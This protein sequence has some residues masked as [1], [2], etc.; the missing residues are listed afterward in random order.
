[1]AIAK[2][3]KIEIIALEKGQLE[4][5]A[6][7]QKLGIVQLIS[8]QSQDD[9]LASIG[10]YSDA[11]LLAIEEAITYLASFKERSFALGSIVQFK[12]L[13]YQQQLQ[14]VITKF[15]YQNLLRELLHLRNH[16]KITVQHKDRLLQERQL[17]APWEKLNLSLEDIHYQKHCAILLGIL[18]R[19]DYQNLSLDLDTQQINCYS[20]IINQDRDNL[21]LTIFYIKEDFERLEDFLKNHRFNFVTLSRHKCLVKERI[22][23]I[24]REMMVLDDQIAE[25]KLKISAL[26][27][28]QLQLMVV[29]DYLNNIRKTKE[30]EKNLA[31]QQFTFTLSGWVREKDIGKLTQIIE[32]KFKDVALFISEPQ[33]DD[34]IPVALENKRL[35][36]PFEF[37]TQIYGMPQYRELDPTP[38]L[39]PFF[40]LYFGFCV[41]DV[42]YGLILC[43]LCLFI[44]K[45]IKMGTQGKKFF[46]LFFYCGISTIIVGA[47]TGSWFGN[48]IDL[49]ADSNQIFLPLQKFKNALIV[50]DPLKEPTKLLGVALVLGI[51]QVWFGNFVAGIGNFKNKRYIEIL[52][53]QVPMFA[54]LFG[55]TGLGLVFLKLRGRENLNLFKFAALCGGIGLVLTQGRS[56]KGIAGK[57]FYGVYNLYNALSGYLSDILSYSR[58]WA[59]GLVT[60]VMAAT[61]NLIS[62]Q[63][64][65]IFVSLIPVVNK[66]GFLKILIASII[67]IAIF[68]IGHLVAFLMNLLGAF[69]HPVRLQFVE[70][71]S[72][73][74]KS[75]GR[76]FKP[77]Q[78]ETKY[79][80][81][82]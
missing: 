6:L 56:E 70:F 37:I 77:F 53:D 82:R 16:L 8:L 44:L 67:L 13:L 2:I 20:E 39:A 18:N 76:I 12:P 31:R 79:I 65:Q 58:L 15:D 51:I 27:Q 19:R 73:F 10:A 29:F 34:L 68:L 5:L 80:N 48:L 42:G 1:M 62:V 63:F 64:S 75:G 60:G 35:I 59:L 46:R 32:E 17:L 22:F 4:L 33:A 11:N 52:L 47:L 50:L 3:K 7:L 43:A 72:K 40:F 30:A 24:N 54:L 28:Q 66:I 55:L 21:Y 26:A 78:I 69:V 74:F 41:S 49:I 57:L 36:Q 45:K 71:F 81:F 9:N 61:V 23:E 38:F 14:E 25:A